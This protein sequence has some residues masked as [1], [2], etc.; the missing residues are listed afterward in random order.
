M[1]QSVPQ[2]ESG[3]GEYFAGDDPGRS[4]DFCEDRQI[5]DSGRTSHNILTVPS[6]SLSLPSHHT[7]LCIFET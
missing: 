4:T 2:I 5:L 6:L 3:G 1:S 7:R